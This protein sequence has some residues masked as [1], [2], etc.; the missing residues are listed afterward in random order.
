MIKNEFFKLSNGIKIPKVGYGTWLITDR[1]ECINGVLWAL[2]AGYRHIDTAA[3]YRNE[4]FIA[5]A[6]KKT[7]VAREDIFITSKL[8]ATKKGY[9]VAIEEFNKSLKRLDT[10]YLD[11]YLIHAPRPWGDV[12]DTDYTQG[13]IDSWLAMIDLYKQGKIKSIGVSNFSKNDIEALKKATNFTP[14]VNQIK[15]HIGYNNQ[16]TKEYCEENN[17]LVEAYCPLANGKIFAET[18][19]AQM[20]KK[21][22][23]SLAQFALRWCLEYNTLPLPKSVREERIIENLDLDFNINK[24]DMNYLLNWKK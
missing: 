6:L 3:V 18:E 8:E 17:I 4:E 2:E 24:E 22:K 10:E 20:A 9:E 21:Y 13:N 11:L 1:M 23:V 16:E 7:S 15:I 19:L 14:H 12:S 5:E